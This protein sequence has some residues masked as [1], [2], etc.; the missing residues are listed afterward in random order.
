MRN[1]K[2][3]GLLLGAVSSVLVLLSSCGDSSSQQPSQQQQQPPAATTVWGT[4]T[5][6]PPG[7]TVTLKDSSSTPQ[8][9]TTTPGANGEFSFDVS[10]L[11]A[12]FLLKAESADGNTRLY[13]VAPDRG[14]ANINA[15]THAAMDT[16]AGDDDLDDG[17]RS[18]SPDRSRPEGRWEGTVERQAA[19][20]APRAGVRLLR[21]R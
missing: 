5:D 19:A 3:L 7:S 14:Q 6:V 13:S 1:L 11:E 9:R 8:L 20:R 17:F 15:L 2:R 16:A 21:Y 10:N 18:Q 12:P 4:V